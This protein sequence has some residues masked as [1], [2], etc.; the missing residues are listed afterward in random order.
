MTTTTNL[1]TKISPT[2]YINS[3]DPLD[4]LADLDDWSADINLFMQG[5]IDTARSGE[6][7]LKAKAKETWENFQWNLPEINPQ[8][9]NQEN[10]QP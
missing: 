10:P 7:W 9:D 1:E 2:T 6:L 5:L 8:G 4:N 3:L